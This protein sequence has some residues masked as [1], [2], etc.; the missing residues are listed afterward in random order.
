[1]DA[2][3]FE[4]SMTMPGDPRLVVAVRDLTA[5]AAGYAGAGQAATAALTDVVAAAA[6]AA[7]DATH[8]KDAP[9]HLQFVR[10]SDALLV[11]IACECAGDTSV[12]A[13]TAGDRI[14][15]EWTRDGARQICRVRQV[16]PA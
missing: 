12:P 15:V 9:V 1:M 10:E 2:T 11:T 14:T 3:S 6:E 4:F 16:L 8:V 5:H 7:I 13:A